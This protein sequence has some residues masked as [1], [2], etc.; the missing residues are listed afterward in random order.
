MNKFVSLAFALVATAA[1]AVAAPKDKPE[2][3]NEIIPPVDFKK[4]GESVSASWGG[5]QAA[6]GLSDT[7][8]IATAGG[9]GLGAGAGYGA[10]GAGAGAGYDVTGAGAGVSSSGSGY[11]T[12]SGSSVGIVSSKPGHHNSAVQG[13]GFFDRIF[14]IPINVLQSVN[15]Y[16][17]QKPQGNR[18]AVVFSENGANGGSAFVATGGESG[19]VPQAGAASASGFD[20]GQQP[21]NGGASGAGSGASG[22]GPS[23]PKNYDQVF[24]IPISALRSVQNLLNG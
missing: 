23:G 5:F 9:N 20:Y 8:A 12:G 10:S 7:G 14:A 17:N 22:A 24:N 11:G 3:S 16:L 19:K 21:S 4:N 1:L 15:T 6:A 18:K 13:N 2:L